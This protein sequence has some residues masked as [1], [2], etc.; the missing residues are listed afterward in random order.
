MSNYKSIS[1]TFLALVS[2]LDLNEMLQMPARFG[3]EGTAFI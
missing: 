2:M 3:L 1:S